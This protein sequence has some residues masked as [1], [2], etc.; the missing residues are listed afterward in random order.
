MSTTPVRSTVAFGTISIGAVAVG[1]FF[2]SVRTVLFA[3]GGTGLFAVLLIYYVNLEQSV[4]ATV[5][6]QV[7]AAHA[8]TYAELASE[9]ELKE[10]YVYV[11]V[12]QS[13]PSDRGPVRLFVP[14]YAD[15]VLPSDDQ[16]RAVI[17]EPPEPRSQGLSVQPTGSD[18][19]ETFRST[20]L[21]RVSNSPSVLADQLAEGLV[22]SLEIATRATPHVTTGE[23]RISITIEGSA[24]G[25][26]DRFDHPIAS[27]V[28][29]GIA[30]QLSQPVE[31]S[32]AADDGRADYVITCRWALA[33]ERPP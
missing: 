1:V 12:D 25:A 30:L 10:S 23:K 17:V 9:L 26:V 18:L 21:N 27:F 22:D 6:E 15:Y 2:P 14:R 16:L 32:V 11:P 31:L 33:N 20:M 8:D 13:G 28:A 4:S 29:T 19:F 7:Y 24:F 5:S 3:L